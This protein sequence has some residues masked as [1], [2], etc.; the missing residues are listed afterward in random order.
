MNVNISNERKLF[1]TKNAWRKWY[2]QK[3]QM[4]IMQMIM[5]FFQI[6]QLKQQ[7]LR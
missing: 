3:L 5:L 1:H 4:K 2:L 7:E 6:Y